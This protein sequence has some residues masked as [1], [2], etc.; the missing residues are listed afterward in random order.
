MKLIEL[1]QEEHGISVWLNYQYILE[2]KPASY[3]N[4]QVFLTTGKSYVVRNK[5]QEILRLIEE[6]RQS[7]QGT[8]ETEG[9]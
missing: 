7:E 3:G 5:P 8:V 1:I 6:A 9:T 2:M 4:T